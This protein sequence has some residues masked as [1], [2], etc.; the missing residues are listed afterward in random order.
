MAA[1]SARVL[2]WDLPG[3]GR[4]SPRGMA[5]PRRVSTSS[6]FP[7]LPS[8]V[9]RG[10]PWRS[11]A[12]GAWGARAFPAC[13][14][15]VGCADC[16]G[17]CQ[18]SRPGSPDSTLS[19]PLG[20]RMRSCPS[21]P[22]GGGLGS[23]GRARGCVWRGGRGWPEAE[24]HCSFYQIGGG[25]R[26][27]CFETDSPRRRGKGRTGTLFTDLSSRLGVGRR[28]VLSRDR[29]HIWSCREHLAELAHEPHTS[30]LLVLRCLRDPE[31]P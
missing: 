13:M 23:W 25:G 17:R 22:G 30:H 11:A 2:S 4:P 6:P 20:R 21:H 31:G 28:R 24:K 27:P 26:T 5:R 9:L 8:A 16:A 7:H 1:G 14:L 10:T 15:E 12:A 18:P 3:R 19:L 29:R